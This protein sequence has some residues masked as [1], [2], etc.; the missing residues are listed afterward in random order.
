MEEAQWFSNTYH[1]WTGADGSTVSAA[2]NWSDFNY[3][4]SINNVTY[5][6]DA[7]APR[8]SW[9]AKM[10]NLGLIDNTALVDA[11]LEFLALEIEG[12]AVTAKQILDVNSQNIVGRNEIRISENGRVQLAGGSLESLRWLDIKDGGELAGYGG[13]DAAL[14][15]AGSLT[16]VG[17][18]VASVVSDRVLTVS[19]LYS[20]T[21]TANLDIYLKSAGN[22]GLDYA[23]VQVTESA[24][25]S[26]EL[27]VTVD[28]DFTPQD[29]DSFDILTADSID[30]IFSNTDNLVTG[31]NGSLFV[32]SYGS[33]TVTLTVKAST[34]RGTPYS[35]LDQYGL[36]VDG[37]Y[38][39]AE[40]SNTDGD[41]LQAWEEYVFGSDPTDR[42]S[43]DVFRVSDNEGGGQID[44]V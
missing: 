8:L 19:G 22:A 34:S 21:D 28:G 6:T 42:F 1:S 24:T 37:D 13:V 43:N 10:Q 31:S 16:V 32:I 5:Q 14:Y 40:L 7:G 9:T 15:N 38:E 26:G 2:A 27:A 18:D 3:T 36:V 41:N 39:A 29:G 33:D 17:E 35:W 11:N 44:M 30:G 12:A 25:L 4:N 23:Q 20:E